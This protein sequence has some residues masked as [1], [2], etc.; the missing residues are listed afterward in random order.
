MPAVVLAVALW[1][2]LDPASPP[3]QPLDDAWLGLMGGAHGGLPWAVA[4]GFDHGAE[5][6]IAGAALLSS[7]GVLTALRR[8][9]SAL[10]VLTAF[11]A[12]A[13]V[14]GLLKTIGDRP[15]PEDIMVDV[16]SNAFPSGHSSRVACLVV[17]VAVVA[18][19]AAGRWWWPVGALLVLGMV[20]ARTWQ[21]AHWLTD[22]IGGVATGL[23]VA[24]LCWRAFDPM[25]RRE[26]SQRAGGDPEAPP[27]SG[28][29]RSGAAD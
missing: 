23:G 9:R 2:R 12:T 29:A 18:I 6:R 16:S 7:A 19:P 28:D 8:W 1:V 3:F 15:R 24:M 25:L 11:A 26:R 4:E 22:T 27:R 10:F 21:H 13:A 20:W 5:G 17:V 14:T